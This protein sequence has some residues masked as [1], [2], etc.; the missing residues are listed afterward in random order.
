[1]TVYYVLTVL[2]ATTA[3]CVR[4]NT[5]SGESSSRRPVF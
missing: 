3:R 1:V 2:L 4:A 5:D